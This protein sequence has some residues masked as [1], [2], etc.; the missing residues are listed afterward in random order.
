MLTLY[1]PPEPPP[2]D[3]R[4]IFR[5][6]H[7]ADEDARTELS[8]LLDRALEEMLPLIT[9]R[10]VYARLPVR[11]TED[12]LDLTFSVTR[13]RALAANLQNADEIVLFAATVGLGADR[14]IAR[15]AARAPSY[16]LLLD[17]IADE[18][19]E[20]LADS[21]CAT[22]SDGYTLSPRFSPGYG[23]LPLDLQ[24]DVFNYLDCARKIG[25][26]LNESLLMSPAKSVTALFGIT[27][28]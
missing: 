1:T 12:T 7:V 8:P 18:R 2:V 6:A 15:H 28:K 23:D 14:L 10:A 9:Y 26:H 20:A 3:R 25:L 13:S 11:R 19:I 4:E 24:R 21:L 27:S 16:A 5:Y 17:A 22:F